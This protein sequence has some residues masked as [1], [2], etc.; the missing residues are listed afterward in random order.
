MTRREEGY[1]RKLTEAAGPANEHDPSEVLSIHD[2]VVEKEEGLADKLHYD[3][4]RRSALVDHF[5]AAETTLEEF[6]SSSY[7]EVGDFVSKPFESH[8]ERTV[9]GV[10]ANLWRIGTVRF[11]NAEGPI[12]LQKTVLLTGGNSEITIDYEITNLD[13]QERECWFGSEFNFALLAGDAPDRYYTFPDRALTDARLCSVGEEQE[14]REVQLTDEWLALRISL[15]LEQAATIW[16][17]PIETVS[18]SEAGFER[19][20]QSSAVLPNWKFRLAPEEKWCA[21]LL[22]KL[23]VLDELSKS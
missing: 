8:V 2:L 18:Q 14:A 12:R 1:H 4:Y 9:G 16:R 3:W 5:L 10:A 22:L 17:F 7:K 15:S 13:L 23:E 11:P 20:Y 19:V 6:A 21:R